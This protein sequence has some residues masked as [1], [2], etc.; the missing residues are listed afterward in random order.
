VS[1]IGHGSVGKTSL[2]DSILLASGA[3]ER[4]GSVADGT[5][6]FD[7]TTESR[8]RKQSLSSS[9]AAC[10][11][12]DHRITIIDTP[13][14]ADFYG[15]VIGSIAVSDGCVLV[16]DGS[17]GVEVG[18]LQTWNF[19]ARAGVPV[20]LWVN[21]LDRENADFDRV[22]SQ[23]RETLNKRIIPLSFPI[24]A[25]GSFGG[26]VSVL[27]G[28]AVDPSGKT[29]PVPPAEQEKLEDWRHEL[30]ES[31][32]EADET[33]M[34]SFFANDTLTPEEL[35]TGLMAA[36]AGRQVFLT[37]C[38]NAVPWGDGRKPPLRSSG[39]ASGPLWPAGRYSSR[40]AGTPCRGGMEGSPP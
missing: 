17:A 28:T 24:T 39:P 12:K 32:A 11:W 15:E 18:S 1:F 9:I 3:V 20:M 19:A 4:L 2:C 13:G 14:S 16:L 26:V 37:A 30:V 6:V 29:I 34:E 25:G 21:R 5:S 10:E 40:H 8:E 7:H 27:D 33:L 23:A 38:G 35:R 31:A 22:V 36:V